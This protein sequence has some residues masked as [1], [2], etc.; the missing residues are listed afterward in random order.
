[1]RALAVAMFCLAV[2]AQNQL[3][4]STPK[5]AA[6]TGVK[7]VTVDWYDSVADYYRNSRR[8]VMAINQKGVPAE[9]IP[10][11]LFIARHSSALTKPSD[12][13]EKAG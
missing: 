7:D 5:P 6:E 2:S 1:M 9:E 3:P 12:R 4:R 10:A 13:S 11:V 8:A